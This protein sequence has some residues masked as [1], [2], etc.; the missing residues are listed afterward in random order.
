VSPWVT[1]WI[2]DSLGGFGPAFTV[3]CVV[4]ASAVLALVVMA[5]GER[6]PIEEVEVKG[7]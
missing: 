1:G 7:V 2:A 6:E 3:S 4:V 5:R